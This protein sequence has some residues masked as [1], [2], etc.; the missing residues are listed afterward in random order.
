MDVFPTVARLVGAKLPEDHVIDGKDIWPILSGQPGAKSPHEVF[1]Y[2]WP[3]GLRAVRSG[4]WKLHLPHKYGS[5]EG[6]EIATPTFHGTYAEAEIG[7]SL[8]DLEE[9]IGETRDVSAKNPDVV[10]RLLALAE[11]AREELGDSLTG[12]VGNGVRGPSRR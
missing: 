10:E 5:I 1:Y 9:D 7:L 6:A 3:S 8:F 11:K 12:R 2:Y 4:K